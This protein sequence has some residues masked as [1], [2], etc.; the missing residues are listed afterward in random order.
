MIRLTK[1]RKDARLS[2]SALAR[3]ADM[4]VSSISQIEAQRLRPYPGQ[5]VKLVDALGW[6]GDPMELFEEVED[7][8]GGAF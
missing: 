3:K 6:E 2:M 4:H 7:R 1:E 8:E 5:V